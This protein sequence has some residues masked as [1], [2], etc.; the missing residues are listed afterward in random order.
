MKNVGEH[1]CESSNGIPELT[2][3]ISTEESNILQYRKKKTLD[4]DKEDKDKQPTPE[5]N[6]SSESNTNCENLQNEPKKNITIKKNSIDF[7]SLNENI[8][9]I[10]IV[11]SE[12]D[13]NDRSYCAIGNRGDKTNDNDEKDAN[14][15]ECDYKHDAVSPSKKR[16]SRCSY[17]NSEDSDGSCIDD[18]NDILKIKNH[19]NME[20]KNRTTYISQHK[21]RI[22]DRKKEKPSTKKNNLFKSNMLKINKTSKDN[23]KR[24]SVA[25]TMLQNFSNSETEYSSDCSYDSEKF[26]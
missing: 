8:F 12:K 20:K 21:K 7:D 26:N 16:D 18:I 6:K 11:L 24:A 9:N 14:E 10:N 25:T 4:D 2:C 22:K 23:V 15:N 13:G 3:N 5:N 17:G 1:L 19:Q